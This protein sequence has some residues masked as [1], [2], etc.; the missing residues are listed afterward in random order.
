MNKSEFITFCKENNLRWRWAGDNWHAA[1]VEGEYVCAEI[2][3]VKFDVIK[4]LLEQGVVSLAIAEIK[5]GQSW[6]QYSGVKLYTD[7]LTFATQTLAEDYENY[8]QSRDNVERW[9]EEEI[10]NRNKVLAEN[11]RREGESAQAHFDRVECE[12][13]QALEEEDNEDDFE[14]LPELF[15]SEAGYWA[16][17]NSGNCLFLSDYEIKKGICSY[18]DDNWTIEIIAVLNEQDEED[19]EVE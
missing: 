6:Y 5:S 1:E 7:N 15:V 17:P 14:P 3:E 2:D 8:L 19:E 16:D 11:S 18:S 10:E 9:S 4:P 13:Y 12:R